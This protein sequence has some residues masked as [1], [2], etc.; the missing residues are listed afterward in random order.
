MIFDRQGNTTIITQESVSIAVFLERLHEKYEKFKSDNI[1]I[2]LFSLDN[3]TVNDLLEFS[4]I[5]RD[6]KKQKKSF[7]IVTNR[8]SYDELPDD[9]VVVPSLQ[10]AFDIIE[11]DEIERDL[12]F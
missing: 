3:I 7:V 6:H 1:I 4:D 11:M 5:S 10:E 2:N 12:G 8:I 9:L